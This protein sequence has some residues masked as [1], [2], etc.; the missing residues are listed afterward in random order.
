M[1]IKYAPVPV[2]LFLSW[3]FSYYHNY[4]LIVDGTI[5]IVHNYIS[6]HSQLL[7]EYVHFLVF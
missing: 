1:S 3:V 7:H 6:Y 2:G 4:A 5:Y